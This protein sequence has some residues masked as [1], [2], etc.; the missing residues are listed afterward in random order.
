VRKAD[1]RGWPPPLAE[2]LPPGHHDQAVRSGRR[3]RSVTAPARRPVCRLLPIGDKR[4]APGLGTPYAAFVPVLTRLPAQELDIPPCHPGLAPFEV[5]LPL[6]P[7]KVWLW[8]AVAVAGLPHTRQ[9][10]RAAHGE[11]QPMQSTRGPHAPREYPPG[12]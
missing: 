3:A 6:V 11:R 8:T 1:L 4:R 2:A 7:G 12:Y 10:P 5:G 9:A